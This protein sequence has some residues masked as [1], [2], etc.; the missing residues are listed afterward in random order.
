MA[1]KT[2]RQRQVFDSVIEGWNEVLTDD[3]EQPT[4]LCRCKTESNE[5]LKEPPAVLCWLFSDRGRPSQ[6][7]H[8]QLSMYNTLFTAPHYIRPCS[9]TTCLLFQKPKYEIRWKIIESTDG[10]N[11][12]FVDPAQLPYNYKWEFPRDKLRLGTYNM[13]TC[14]I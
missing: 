1:D 3:Q 5:E 11:Y 2:K 13:F 6:P 8:S 14:N 9:L 7:I 10:N 12:T 4:R